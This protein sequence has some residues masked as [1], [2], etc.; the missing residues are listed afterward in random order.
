MNNST[1]I[2]RN[3]IFRSATFEGMADENG[4]PTEEYAQLYENLAKNG[5]KNIIT[6]FT[7]ISKEGRAIHPGQAGIDTDSWE[8]L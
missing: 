8:K 5:V 2:F 6:G 3:K 4:F 7:Y 1:D